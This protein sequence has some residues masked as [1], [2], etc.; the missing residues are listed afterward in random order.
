MEPFAIDQNELLQDE[1]I[2]LRRYYR[3]LLKRWW[4]VL[5]ITLVVSVPW[6]LYIKSQPPVYEA[7]TLIRFNDSSG[8]EGM[9]QR[10][11]TEIKS[12]SFAE[13]VVAE[14][15]LSMSFDFETENL[16]KRKQVFE[17]FSTTNH[18]VPGRYVLRLTDAQLYELYKRSSENPE[19]LNLLQRG[20]IADV[21]NE[22]TV[23]NG[24]SFRFVDEGLLIPA[25]I[26]FKISAFPKAVISFQNRINV[27]TDRTGTLM[28]I[29][30]TDTD[31]NLVAEMTNHLAEIFIR[32]TARLKNEG[33][34]SRREII[35]KQ[36]EIVTQELQEA[37]RAL[38][39]FKERHPIYLNPNSQNQ[40]NEMAQVQNNERRLNEAIKTLSDLLVK[41]TEESLAINGSGT[42]GAESNARFLMLQI[43]KQK[44]FDSDATMLVYRQELG[45]LESDW[46]NIATRLS[47]DN[48]KAKQIMEKIQQ[49]HTKIETQALSKITN[50][51]ED[52]SAVI[53]ERKA[54]E[55]QLG[56]LPTLELQ[57]SELTRDHKVKE[58]KYTDLLARAQEAR[59]DEAVV[60]NDAEILDTAIVPEL[61]TNRDKKKN[62]AFGGLFGLILGIS[63]V[64]SIEFLDKS[65]KTVDDVKRSLQLNVLGT[66]PKIDFNDVYDFQDSEKIKQ[67]DQQLVTH[68]YSPTPV[69]EAYRSLRTNL[70]F[71]N[72]N[73]Q[74]R[75]LVVTSNE[76]GDGKSFTAAN[77]S[78]TL[79]QLK[80]NTLLIDA[81]LRRGVL[82]NTF[83]V[84]K[85]PGFSNY[86]T[87][88]VPLVNILRE[89]HIP[90]LT[91]I[92]C[93]S[94]IPNPS[95]LLG[96]HQM[97][98]FLDEVRRKFELIIF[99]TPPLN[100][101]TDAVVV[102]TQVDGSVI[103]IRAGKTHRDLAKQK[104]ELFNQ[105]PAKVFGTVLNGTT[106]DMAHPGY[107]YY[108]Y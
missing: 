78:I 19:Q 62:A 6:G 64:L 94:L 107:S 93:G 98:R 72:K 10:R 106:A 34:T 105:V 87:N 21:V 96:S 42:R 88:A 92:S 22:F 41:K 17:D 37:S 31:P 52:L 86:L 25:E 108:H 11:R 29:S 102:G 84:T 12:R 47:P 13:R 66:I 48:P 77:L 71:S 79:A 2:D 27:N 75:S 15:G 49:L 23:V 20:Q 7:E 95:E 89:T 5:L 61:P 43:V 57:L 32:H 24:F 60:S 85:E 100:A 39:N 40:T 65:L 16:I 69:G 63:V 53:A 50:L 74:I 1:K 83:G 97:R 26:P 103:V 3:A 91:L 8:N 55:R 70:M 76:P 4:L 9:M 104:L 82:H 30:L 36:L 101:A 33:I 14:L 99:D 46:N 44:V 59:I 90:N 35:D 38:K 51:R 18:P 68:D 56:Q 54:L 73:G 67:I 81:D 45:Q 28:S 58:R 80:T